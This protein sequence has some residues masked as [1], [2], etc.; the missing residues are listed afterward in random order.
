LQRFF[1]ALVRRDFVALQFDLVALCAS[2]TPP[3]TEQ[4]S[5]LSSV[6]LVLTNGCRFP[7][8]LNDYSCSRYL[9]TVQLT[10]SS[11]P[12]LTPLAQLFSRT[13]AS[14]DSDVST[15]AL[16]TAQGLFTLQSFTSRLEVWT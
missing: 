8:K 5:G 3:K 11:P 14:R 16:A 12:G 1:G 2:S 10:R 13:L 7:L 9:Q 4:R 6:F 15:A